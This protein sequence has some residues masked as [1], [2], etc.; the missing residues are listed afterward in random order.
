[1]RKDEYYAKKCPALRVQRH[2]V[3]HRKARFSVAGYY[4]LLWKYCEKISR[5]NEKV[6]SRR[7]RGGAPRAFV[8]LPPR[9]LV[10]LSALY[11]SFRVSI[12]KR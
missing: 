3:V 10:T 2:A 6:T 11:Y 12:A 9:A 5:S 8:T 7:V 4:T 1:M